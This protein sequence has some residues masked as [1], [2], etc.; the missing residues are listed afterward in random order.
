VTAPG[1][2]NDELLVDVCGLHYDLDGWHAYL[3]GFARYAPGYLRKFAPR[4]CVIA[5]ADLGIYSTKLA[6]S[7]AAAVD[8]LIEC[9]GGF[10]ESFDTYASRMREEG[11]SH[12][13][14]HGWG[15]PDRNERDVNLRVAENAARAPDLFRH[16]R[17]RTLPLKPETIRRWIGA[18]ARYALGLDHLAIE[19]RATP[20]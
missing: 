2:G 1:D 17:P 4:F 9:G 13:I 11:L 15:W 18:N 6:E 3:M 8:Y 14:L 12:Q 5:R 20:G 19:R 10:D 7:A 16:G